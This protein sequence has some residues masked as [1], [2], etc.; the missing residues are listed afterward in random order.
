MKSKQQPGVLHTPKRVYKKT[1][2]LLAAT[3]IQKKLE[4]IKLENSRT[5]AVTNNL[6]LFRC[7]V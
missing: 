1:S 7:R 6:S 3:A 5:V 4:E 2:Y